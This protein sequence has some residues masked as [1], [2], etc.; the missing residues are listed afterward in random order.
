M[1]TPLV[2]RHTSTRLQGEKLEKSA[3]LRPFDKPTLLCCGGLFTNS[4]NPNVYSFMEGF[5]EIGAG[6]LGVKDHDID[7]PVDI[8]SVSYPA[9]ENALVNNMHAQT[10]ALHNGKRGEPTEFARRF[11]RAYLFPLVE[12]AQ[13]R[14]LPLEQMCRNLS[15]VRILSHS[16]GGVFAQHLNIALSEHLS[17]LGVPDADIRSAMKQ[18]VWVTAGTPTAIGTSP[19]PFTALHVLNH[20]DHEAMNSIDFRKAVRPWLHEAQ[21]L[22]D[23][24]GRPVLN[25]YLEKDA[26]YYASR[27]LSILPVHAEA[28]RQ[29]LEYRYVP[30]SSEALMYL[31]QPV[32]INGLNKVIPKVSVSP[33]LQRS[34]A[35]GEFTGRRGSADER[36]HR[37]STYFHFGRKPEDSGWQ[38]MEDHNALMPRMVI[39]SILVNAM[40][41]S[42]SDPAKVPVIDELLALPSK[43]AYASDSKVPFSHLAKA[44]KYVHRV[45][46]ARSTDPF[47]QNVPQVN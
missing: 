44:E 26:T 8:V 13:H 35:F 33:H 14:A 1:G 41:L 19:M 18:V 16:Y 2:Y 12:D 3:R 7:S 6:L 17:A 21:A 40:N 20:D 28:G 5:A 39:S 31:A 37:A 38:H 10:E 25:G 34:N 36:G 29:R 24:V 42:V 32:A 47:S 46:A 27:P 22:L 30:G 4:D 23:G 11:A 45:E 9:R 15:N 43:L